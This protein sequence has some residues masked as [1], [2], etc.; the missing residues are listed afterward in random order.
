MDSH[1]MHNKLIQEL[2]NEQGLFKDMQ[3]GTFK[4][5]HKMASECCQ[6]VLSMDSPPSLLGL[7]NSTPR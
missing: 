6:R 2:R 1:M 4:E 5:Q 3:N 7:S